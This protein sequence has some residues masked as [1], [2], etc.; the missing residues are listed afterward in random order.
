MK[1]L[2][3]RVQA[4]LENQD[5]VSF[6]QLLIEKAKAQQNN[7]MPDWVVF[8]AH[9]ESI[10]HDYILAFEDFTTLINSSKNDDWNALWFPFC[11]FCTDERIF[12]LYFERE[13]ESGK[14]VLSVM[15]VEVLMGSSRYN[16][17]NHIEYFIGK[18]M[19]IDDTYSLEYR[20]YITLLMLCEGPE[21]SKLIFEAIDSSLRSRQGFTPAGEL[22]E[23]FRA[24]H[25]LRILEANPHE[26]S[27][28]KAIERIDKGW[29]EIEDDSGNLPIEELLIHC[30][31]ILYCIPTDKSL[32]FLYKGMGWHLSWWNHPEIRNVWGFIDDTLFTGTNNFDIPLNDYPF[33]GGGTW[34]YMSEILDEELNLIAIEEL[35][36]QLR[37]EFDWS[38]EDEDKDEFEL[39]KSNWISDGEL[40]NHIPFN[41]DDFID[42]DKLM[43][44]KNI[45]QIRSEVGI[46]E[47]ELEY[48][49]GRD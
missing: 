39:F 30:I 28:D 1:D 34:T 45:E 46:G 10:G 2:S 26:E 12:D 33:G 48:I 27:V 35:Y 36:L 14:E 25:L 17:T 47:F 42:N 18:V 32:K 38:N 11:K 8:F 3:D 29:G 22:V 37:N 20:Y 6:T 16:R 41:F 24:G 7:L 4:L 23:H 15:N 21:F 40:W 13:F 5:Y 19:Q 43:R 49:F 31:R 44:S 9:L